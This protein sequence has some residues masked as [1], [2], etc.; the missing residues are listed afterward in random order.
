MLGSLTIP[1]N[2]WNQ[3]SSKFTIVLFFVLSIFLPVDVSTSLPSIFASR[4]LTSFAIRSIT[5]YLLDSVSVL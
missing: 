2:F 5:M 1:R 3:L 4:S